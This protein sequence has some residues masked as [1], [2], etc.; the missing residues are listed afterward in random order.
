MEVP[1]IRQEIETN[2][3]VFLIIAFEFGVAN[4]HNLE[5]DTCQPQPI[6]E[7]TPLRPYLN[8]GETFSKSTSLRMMKNMIKALSWRFCKY[9]G[10]FHM[11]T[12]KACS[13][14]ALFRE[15]SNKAFHIL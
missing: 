2:F 5:D 1:E 6:C 3:L 4:S 7:Q 10:R 13:E 14:T 9:L 11:L 12:V 8:P 15:W